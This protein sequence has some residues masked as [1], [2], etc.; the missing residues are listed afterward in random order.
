[1]WTATDLFKACTSSDV[2]YTPCRKFSQTWHA[3]ENFKDFQNFKTVSNEIPL[4]NLFDLLNWVTQSERLF[5]S[6]FLISA[7][8]WQFS[9]SN[10]YLLFWVS[11]SQSTRH[12]NDPLV[13]RQSV[14]I[15]YH[16]YWQFIL[17]QWFLQFVHSSSSSWNFTCI[18]SH[19]WLCKTL[20]HF[21]VKGLE[22]V[23]LE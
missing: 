5:I 2:E 10:I 8:L 22:W 17:F 9:S 1:M 6:I 23:P 21:Y 11:V 7:L 4:S 16:T 13:E 20:D 14:E 15:F 19:M 18:T 3:W 12:W